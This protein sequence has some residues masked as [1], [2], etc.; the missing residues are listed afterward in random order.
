[1]KTPL[2]YQVT[3]YDCGTASIINA[4][5]YVFDR[6]ELEPDLIHKVNLI[7]TDRFGENGLEHM[8]GTSVQGVK[9]LS[10]WL[11]MY[12]DTKK[13]DIKCRF[14]Q[15]DNVNILSKEVSN[16]LNLGGAVVARLWS[17]CEHYA[18]ITGIDDKHVYLFD[19]EYYEKEVFAGDDLIEVIENKPFQYNRKIAIERIIAGTEEDY[20]L[21]NNEN[22]S[23]LLI[24][25]K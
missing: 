21:V 16:C 17:E 10:E 24:S 14:L 25:R 2:N 20:A 1:M 7:T 3:Q 9:Y 22:K 6:E 11:K 15:G 18:T 23:L 12:G 4:L 13:L 8:G 5:I 19:P